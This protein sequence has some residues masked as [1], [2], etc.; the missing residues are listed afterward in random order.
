M[1]EK[2]CPRCKHEWNYK[3]TAWWITC[4]YCRKLFW[5]DEIVFDEEELVEE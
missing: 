4:P 1:T 5:N 3:G 2:V